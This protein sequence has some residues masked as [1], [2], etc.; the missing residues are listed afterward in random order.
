MIRAL[1]AGIGI[2]YVA[3]SALQRLA[4]HEPLTRHDGETIRA[5]RNRA[6][7]PVLR[8]ALIDHTSAHLES[9]GVGDD[10]PHREAA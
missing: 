5:Y 8:R 7:D 1:L 9:E 3:R 10:V 6:M 4:A 2:G